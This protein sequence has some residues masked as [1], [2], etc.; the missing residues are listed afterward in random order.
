MLSLGQL[1]FF[2]TCTKPTT[3]HV[4]LDIV[5]TCIC[6]MHG[7]Y[8]C[9]FEGVLRSLA[10]KTTLNGAVVVI[11]VMGFVEHKLFIMETG[12]S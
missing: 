1:P 4:L 9:M 10:Y 2:A 7:L 3:L 5:L 6:C 11:R 12:V 8:A